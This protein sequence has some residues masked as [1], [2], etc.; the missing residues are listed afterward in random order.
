MVQPE[1]TLAGINIPTTEF[2][3]TFSQ[4]VWSSTYKDHSDDTIN[5][6]LRRVAKFVASAEDTDS[7]QD[8]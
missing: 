8:P 7:L 5:D 3:D 2:E 4:E 1:V 6:T